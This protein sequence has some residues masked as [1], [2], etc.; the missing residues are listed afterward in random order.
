M[1]R[2][3]RHLIALSAVALALAAPPAARADHGQ[4]FSNPDVDVYLEIAQEHWG[5]TAPTC[6]GPSGER[7]PV[8]V[9]LHDNPNPD[10]VATAEQPGCRMWLDRD[11]W[12]A[13]AGRFACTIIAHE[14]GHLL[15]LGHYR[16]SRDLMYQEPLT[17]AP[18]CSLYDPRVT[19]G[20]AVAQS[21]GPARRRRQRA[22]RARGGV[23]QHRTRRPGWSLRQRVARRR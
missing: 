12:P 14:W 20:T 13:P 9:V 2:A 11:W 19:L 4:P 23:P 21:S 16:D 6:A 15:G 10:V 5:L 1:L 8:H 18:G 3:L 17:G 7:I 22:S